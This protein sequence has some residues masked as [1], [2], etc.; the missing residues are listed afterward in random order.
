MEITNISMDIIN[1]VFAF[2]QHNILLSALAGFA[3]AYIES[4]LPILPLMAIVAA[5]GA[6]NGFAIGFFVSLM[7]SVLGTMSV[8]YLVKYVFKNRKFNKNENAKID[9]LIQ[10]IKKAEFMVIFLFYAIS[11][12]PASLTTIAAAYCGFTYKEFL[13]PMFFGKLLMMSLYAYIGSD[14]KD[15]FTNPYK[16]TVGILIAIVIYII[17]SRVNKTIDNKM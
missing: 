13:P 6:L 16:L 11:I 1:Q 5:N 17:G 15:F 9:L 7:G 8:F 12:L 4:F 3:A 2:A 14:Y 10:K